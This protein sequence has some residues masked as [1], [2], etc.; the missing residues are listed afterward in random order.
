MGIA[1]FLFLL[2]PRSKTFNK[3]ERQRVTSQHLSTRLV[4]VARSPPQVLVNTQLLPRPKRHRTGPCALAISSVV[5]LVTVLI[6]LRRSLS[7]GI[8]SAV[9]VWGLAPCCSG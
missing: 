7:A 5:D 1:S 3:K 9:G 8:T 2:G 4:E 6:L